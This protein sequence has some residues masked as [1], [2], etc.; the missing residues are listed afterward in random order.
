MQKQSP[1][2]VAGTE[3]V[4]DRKAAGWWVLVS[5]LFLLVQGS[6]SMR[7]MLS[8]ARGLRDWPSHTS[9]RPFRS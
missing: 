9:G 5:A 6:L 4:Q 1:T 3:S 8:R 2:D 7:S